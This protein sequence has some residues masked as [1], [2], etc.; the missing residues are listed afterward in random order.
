MYAEPI[1][2][3]CPLH[4][5]APVQHDQEIADDTQRS[6]RHPRCLHAASADSVKI[7]REREE[8]RRVVESLTEGTPVIDMARLYQ[9]YC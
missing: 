8:V 9:V 2:K 6:T 7:D 5:R 1:V 4:L 3:I